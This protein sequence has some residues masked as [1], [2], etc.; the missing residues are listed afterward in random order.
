MNAPSP[1]PKVPRIP[2]LLVIAFLGFLGYFYYSLA[3]GEKR[4]REVCGKIQAGMTR[5]ELAA[6]AEAHGLN[7][8]K[9]TGNRSVLGEGR[10]Y[11]RFTCLVTYDNDRV[12]TSEYHHF[13]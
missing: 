13:D 6:F 12:K 9:P 1:T 7:T 11:G 4:M 10:S 3:T 8:P 5:T 2:L